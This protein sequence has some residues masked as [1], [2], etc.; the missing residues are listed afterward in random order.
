MNGSSAHLT[1]SGTYLHSDLKEGRAAD[2]QVQ[3]KGEPQIKCESPGAENDLSSY[4]Y[5]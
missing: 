4:P 2:K 3:E 1:H 5:L